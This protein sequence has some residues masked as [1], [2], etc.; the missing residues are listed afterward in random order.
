MRERPVDSTGGGSLASYSGPV[1][2]SAVKTFQSRLLH[3]SDL[4]GASAGGPT[5]TARLAGRHDA[6]ASAHGQTCGPGDVRPWP[7]HWGIPRRAVFFSALELPGPHQRRA[8]NRRAACRCFLPVKSWRTIPSAPPGRKPAPEAA[9]FDL[10]SPIP[11]HTTLATE[12]PCCDPAPVPGRPSLFSA[13]LCCPTGSSLLAF[14]AAVSEA[15]HVK[16]G[17]SV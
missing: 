2:G 15:R 14:T 5:V 3:V 11:S 16:A 7:G 9:G 17:P 6:G 1:I 12:H 10:P 8:R 13:Q 4:R